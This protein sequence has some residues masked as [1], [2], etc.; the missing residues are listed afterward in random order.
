MILKACSMN[1]K[2]DRI[3]KIQNQ[4]EIDDIISIEKKKNS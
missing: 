3:I 1:K 4:P 2:D